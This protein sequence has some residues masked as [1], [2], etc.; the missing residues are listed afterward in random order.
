MSKY[1][2]LDDIFRDCYYS[3]CG[4]W[5]ATNKCC[6]MLSICNSLYVLKEMKG[7]AV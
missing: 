2:P 3:K 7:G 4:W 5:D 6:V 1:C